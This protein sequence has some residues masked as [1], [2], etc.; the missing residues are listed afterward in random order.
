MNLNQQNKKT[1]WQSPWQFT[2]SIFIVLGIYLVGIALQLFLGVFKFS[3]IAW[4]VNIILGLLSVV[5]VV[6]ISLK[7][8]SHFFYWLSA[9]PLSISLMALLIIQTI[10]MGLTP[11]IAGQLTERPDVFDLL[12]FTRMTSSW[13]FVLTMFFTIIALCAAIVNRLKTPTWK[14]YAFYL[15]HLGLFIF[16]FAAAYGAADIKRYVMYVE[17]GNEVPEWRVYNDNKDVLDLPLAIKLNDFVLEEYAPKLA[18][19]QRK[20]GKAIPYDNPIYFQ[21]DSLIPTTSIGDWDIEVHEFIAEAMRES[22]KSYR[23]VPM[24]GACPAAYVSVVNKKNKQKFT[25]WVCCGNFA[26]LYMPLT[27]T[28]DFSL[29]MTRPEAKRFA[30]YVD[31][32]TASG[33]QASAV[34]EVNKPFSVDSWSIY[35]YGYD[36]DTGKASSYSSFELVYDPWINYVYGGIFIFAMGCF[37]MFW[38]GNNKRK[39]AN[40]E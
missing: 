34:I 26:Q 18:I 13:P 36:T 37:C 2:E 3:N 10:I 17:V 4:P 39:K 32:I 33:K 14:D 1:I 20:T 22:E 8:K 31:V 35:Q 15:N 19:I 12:G 40:N 16:L 30:S 21:I 24:P 5:L 25:G 27:L 29:V 7:P 38:I 11:Q 6:L 28:K 9:A 23:K